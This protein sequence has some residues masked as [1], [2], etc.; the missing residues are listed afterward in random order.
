VVHAWGLPENSGQIVGGV[1]QV[2][3][4]SLEESEARIA[5]S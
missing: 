1:K 5:E 2:E 4:I 3:Q